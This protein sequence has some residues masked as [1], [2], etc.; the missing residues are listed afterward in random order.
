MAGAWH[1]TRLIWTMVRMSIQDVSPGL[2]AWA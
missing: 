2:S 1:R